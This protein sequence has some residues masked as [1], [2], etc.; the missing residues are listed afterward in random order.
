MFV[1]S[2]L[3]LDVKKVLGTCETPEM[4]RRLSDAVRLGSNQS[5]SNDWNIGEMDICVCD[6][7]VTLPADVMTVL[8]V[9]SGGSPTLIRDQWFQYHING[10][11]SGCCAPCGYTDEVG[12]VVT[13]K[14]PSGPVLLVAVVENALDSGKALRVYGWDEDGKRI[15][16]EGAGGILE[17]GFLVP[18]VFGF[19]TTNPNAPAITRIDRIKKDLTNGFIRLVAIDPTDSTVHTQIGYYMPWETNPTY[20]RIKVQEKSWVRIKYKRRD[21]E[22]RGT[23]DWINIDNREALLLL[24]RAVKYRMDG[25]LE[26]ARNYEIEGMRLL[27]NEAEALRPNAISPPQ[28]IFTDHQAQVDSLYY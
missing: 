15:Y 19:S 27:S 23:G 18:T 17:D 6:C 3:L 9:N 2:T 22:V 10:S 13:Y 4:Y 8:A 24:L 28:V 12:Q 5:K 20:R 1:D 7:C 21:I 26:D 16:T 25:R 14:D 11:G